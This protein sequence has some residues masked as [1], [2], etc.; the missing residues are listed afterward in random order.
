MGG[1]AGGSS[2]LR[3]TGCRTSFVSQPLPRY[4]E[5]V[6]NNGGVGAVVLLLGTNEQG[7]V[8]RRDVVAAVGSAFAQSIDDIDGA[9]RVERAEGSAEGCRLDMMWFQTV[10][11]LFR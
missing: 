7:E 9:W 2:S 4:P 11:Y 6:L 3:G 10:V 8:V 5:R 1:V